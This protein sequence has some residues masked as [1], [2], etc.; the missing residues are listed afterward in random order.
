MKWMND[1]NISAAI[2]KAIVVLYQINHD[3]AL[4]ARLG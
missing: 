3:K 1:F 4:T 2:F